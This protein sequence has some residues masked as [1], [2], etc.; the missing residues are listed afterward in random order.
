MVSVAEVPCIP[1]KNAHEIWKVWV[2]LI[3]PASTLF[4]FNR[5]CFACSNT[6]LE[7]LQVKPLMRERITPIRQRF[8]IL[9]ADFMLRTGPFDHTSKRPSQMK[10]FDPLRSDDTIPLFRHPRNLSMAVKVHNKEITSH[11]REVA[12]THAISHV[13]R[14]SYS[15]HEHS[16]FPWGISRLFPS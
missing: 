2:S 11:G 14:A 16:G 10:K 15:S 3:H 4:R 5:F 7:C 6:N 9:N 8:L 13:A 12:R 1:L